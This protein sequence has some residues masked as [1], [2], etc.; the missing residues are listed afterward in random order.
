M[1]VR[2][3]QIGAVA[4]GLLAVARAATSPGLVISHGAPDQPGVPLLEARPLVEGEP[5][6]YVCRGFVCEAPVTSAEAL[7]AALRH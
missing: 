5:T 4:A 2:K 6:A 3:W 1:H 7:A